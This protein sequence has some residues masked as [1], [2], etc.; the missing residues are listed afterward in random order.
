MIRGEYWWIYCR[1][2]G[3]TWAHCLSG[4]ALP[5][6]EG[7]CNDVN[8]L[9][10]PDGASLV[11]CIPGEQVRI[12]TVKVPA[13]NR[14]RFLEALPYAL[15]DKLLHPPDAYHFVVL[16]NNNRLHTVP[17]AVI[18]KT[19]LEEI[20]SKFNQRGWQMKLMIADYLAIEEPAPGMWVLDVTESP[21]LLRFSEN[22]GGAAISEELTSRPQG[23]LILAMENAE[24]VPQ[25]I[26]VR[27]LDNRQRKLV[28]QWENKIGENTIQLDIVED[29]R[30]RGE[31][32]SRFPLAEMNLLT[33]NYA[34]TM[35]TKKI[36]SRL[37]PVAGLAA[38]I[39]TIL[40][41]QWLIE[42]W[43]I[44]EEYLGLQT[45]IEQTYRNVFPD[46]RNL[47]DPRFQMEQ[48]LSKYR[49]SQ[50]S[51]TNEGFDLLNGLEQLART[52][53][54]GSNQLLK[55]EFENNQITVE[56]SI[57]N[58][59][60][61]EKLQQQFAEVMDVTVERAELRDSRVYSRLILE[62]KT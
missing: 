35:H 46:T 9:P 52:L 56:V 47:I 20:L 26:Q 33:G 57:D 60:S 54:P 59:D 41:A 44:K 43:R 61:L 24:T 8:E 58:Y 40:I 48:Q 28:E 15:E 1:D 6:K 17:V 45:E 55:L 2:S 39:F 21:M 16:A 5:L 12:H 11:V 62:K 49:E 29:G 51:N 36:L 53:A 30:S 14:R 7:A 19:A 22:N 18:A 38:G 3:I 25:R 27:V 37:I 34:A 50:N 23:A 4:D 10:V 32:L 42:G 31:W 13:K